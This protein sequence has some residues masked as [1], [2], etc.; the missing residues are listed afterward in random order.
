MNEEEVFLKEIQTSGN[1]FA[2]GV[3]ADWLEEGGR[4][5]EAEYFRSHLNGD[6]SE[7]LMFPLEKGDRALVM[8]V[9]L[10]YVGEIVDKGVGWIRM[11]DASWVHWTG[12]ISSLCATKDFHRVEGRA[13]RTEIVK[14]VIIS[15]GSIVCALPGDWELPSE[16]IGS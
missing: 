13:P 12:R 8:T 2:V 16:S 11:K 1:E 9:T 10:Y 15:N 7:M 6:R 3:Y 4:T 5:A 14:D